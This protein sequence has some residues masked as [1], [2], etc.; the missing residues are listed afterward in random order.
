M[1]TSPFE[2]I[3]EMS[4]A[5]YTFMEDGCYVQLYSNMLGSE[6]SHEFMMWLPTSEGRFGHKTLV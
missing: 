5:E 3:D 4:V 2:F 1:K 6:Y